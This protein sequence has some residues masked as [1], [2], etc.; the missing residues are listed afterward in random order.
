MRARAVLSSLMLVVASGVLPV[1][2]AAQSRGTING[3]VRD[4]LGA[5]AFA[6]VSL[7][8]SDATVVTDETGRF[9]FTGVPFGTV[10][11]KV[12]RLGYTPT[13]QT[14]QFSKG[15]EPVIEILMSA[16]PGY[17][18]EVTVR[19]PRQVYDSRLQGFK[20]RS[21]KG[22][23]YFI[24][25]ERLE[26]LASYRFSD[27]IRE[28][29]GAR[30]RGLRG[31]GST[32][33]LRGAN[34]APLVFVDGNPAGAGVVDLDMF[35]LGMVEGIEVYSGLAS[36]PPEFVT[37]RGLDRC[38]VVAIWSR[39]YRPKPK[40]PAS[41]QA[42]KSPALDSILSEMSVF[43]V[44]QVDT[45]ASLIAGTAV[46]DY[47]DSLRKEGVEGRVV[48]ELVV[49]VDGNLDPASL[50]LVSSTNQLFTNAVQ[51]SLATA[52]FKAATLRSRPVRQVLQ[53]PFVFKTDK[54][55]QSH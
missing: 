31:G 30:L 13:T 1:A 9:R 50:N 32:I 39:P 48:V 3:T 6:D 22:V 18:P 7:V 52:K 8:G 46:P 36:V 4:S 20:D 38:G 12:R 5:I 45:P 41:L 21:T 55:S 53:V 29:P 19:E 25:R 2:A 42:A 35:D 26:K 16:A 11:L 34:C 14:I 24:T 27:V 40:K 33:N 54:V 37:A 17:L 49:N 15:T 43:T 10:E 51:Q 44:D 23:G 47:P 28:V